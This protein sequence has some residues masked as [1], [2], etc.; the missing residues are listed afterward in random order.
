MLGMR[1]RGTGQES[2]AWSFAQR[3]SSPLA[4]ALVVAGLASSLIG[5]LQ[6]FGVAAG[7]EPWVRQ[8]TY[9]EAFANLRQRNQ[10]AG[11][12]NMAL[13][14]LIW[15]AMT[16]RTGLAGRGVPNLGNA[17]PQA[18]MLVTAALLAVGNAASSS[19]TGLLQLV[20]LCGLCLPWDGW[21]Q[22]VVR[23]ILITA[24]VAYGIATFLLPVMAGLDPLDRGMFARLRD[25]AP[26]CSSR[27]LLWSNVLHLIGQKPWL[28]W[29]WNELDFAHYAV[30]YNGPRFCEILDN[31]HNL[32][33]HLA[34]ELGVPA[35]VLI[36]GSI[37]WWIWHRWPWAETNPARQMAW[38][39]L[40]VIGLHSMLEYPLWYGPFQM[41]AGLC[42]ILLWSPEKPLPDAKYEPNR[43]LAQVIY[44]LIA[45]ILIAC[46]TYAMWDY[47]RISQLYMA[48]QDRDPAYADDTLGKARKSWL[49]SNQ[50]QFA[51]LTT[52]PLSRD[53]AQWTFDTASA[54]LHYSPEPRII[55]KVIESAVILD[56]DDEATVHLA[57]YKAAF[58]KEHAAWARG[59]AR[60]PEMIES[61][62][63]PK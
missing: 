53:N 48:P 8:G 40:A 49:F 14:A 33:L 37:A 30:L 39:V 19:R 1:R 26:A 32:P 58:P 25:G 7:L 42:V 52:T 15:L 3:W 34:V 43:P 24:I 59:N 56:R 51:E 27:W 61:L 20:L 11:L 2:A 36:C 5:L 23:H 18:A 10:F 13:A 47:H 31:A 46:S 41:S 29:G 38:G 55:E 35:A 44:S 9:G 22:V 63:P 57:R 17:L 12:T 6:Y 28:G 4:W 45:I 16:W 62:R 50:V 21:R 60:M 54:L